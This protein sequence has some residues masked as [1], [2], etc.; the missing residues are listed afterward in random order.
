MLSA[1]SSE[2]MNVKIFD[3][4][5]YGTLKLTGKKLARVLLGILNNAADNKFFGGPMVIAKNGERYSRLLANYLATGKFDSS[6]MEISDRRKFD[7]SE[8]DEVR[9]VAGDLLVRFWE[10]LKRE[11]DGRSRPGKKC[12]C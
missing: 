11:K 2:L 5:Q 8:I 6:L 3:Y 12:R 7:S 1:F 9:K 10:I 4:F